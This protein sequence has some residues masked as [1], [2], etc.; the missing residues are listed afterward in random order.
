MDTT[1]AVIAVTAG[2]GT[3]FNHNVGIV[4]DT[5]NLTVELIVIAK[6]AVDGVTV[7]VDCNFCVAGN[8]DGALTE[9]VQAALTKLTI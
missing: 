2:D 3:V 8:E 9:A 7:Q 4:V 6:T 5:D 1:R